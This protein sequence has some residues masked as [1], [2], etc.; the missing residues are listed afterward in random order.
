MNKQQYINSFKQKAFL[1][2]GVFLLLVLIVVLFLIRP[3]VHKVSDSQTRLNRAR[4]QFSEL[5][6]AVGDLLEYR[7]K[8]QEVEG[9]LESF[10]GYIVATATG[11]VPEEKFQ[12]ALREMSP[13]SFGGFGRGETAYAPA[14]YKKQLWELSLSSSYN[15]LFDFIKEIETYEKFVGVTRLEIKSGEFENT[16]KV[17]L[18]LYSI[19]DEISET[20][21]TEFDDDYVQLLEL[22]ESVIE[23][24]E[25]LM[26]S[27]GVDSDADTLE[28]DRDPFYFKN[29]LF[30]EEAPE[31][32]EAPP[33]P[34]PSPPRLILGGI[35]WDD[36]DTVAVINGE[37]FREGESVRGARV[38]RIE[39]NYVLLQ[40]RGRFIRLE[41]D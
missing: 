13:V 5:N 39:R 14:G 22:S 37:I 12:G 9:V 16:H 35:V 34:P 41:I 33:A 36:Q 31:T 18:T 32:P 30:I 23:T 7:E 28:V 6:A 4:R 1:G 20:L 8:Q 24:V 3:A 40:W 11:P 2:G 26:L 10:S 27:F 25:G 21:P 17:L 29:T 19:L 15:D 38:E